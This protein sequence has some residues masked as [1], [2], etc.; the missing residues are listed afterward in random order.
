MRSP[1]RQAGLATPQS[2]FSMMAGREQRSLHHHQLQWG[3]VGIREL[4]RMLSR[5]A[6]NIYFSG[7]LSLGH[8]LGETSITFAVTKQVYVAQGSHCEPAFAVK[9]ALV[10]CAQ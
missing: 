6:G 1:L 5:Y 9:L 3:D 10:D 2:Y 4:P 8:M 7:M